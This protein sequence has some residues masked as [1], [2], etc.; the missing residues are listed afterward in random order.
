MALGKKTGGRTKGVLNKK[1]EAR[2]DELAKIVASGESPLSFM[3]RK[4]RDP[5]VLDDVRADMAKAA[6]PYVHPRLAA[7]EH[8]GTLNVTHEDVLDQLE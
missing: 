3:L 5:K 8:S 1:T 6:A 7:L 4:M 2:K